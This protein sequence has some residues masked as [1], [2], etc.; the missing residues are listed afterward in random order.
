MRPLRDVPLL[1]L[2]A[3][4]QAQPFG[5]TPLD[6]ET[7]GRSAPPTESV[8]SPG[9]DIPGWED[10]DC[11]EPADGAG[12]VEM[13]MPDVA[14]TFMNR[15]GGLEADYA[16]LD[17]GVCDESPCSDAGEFVTSNQPFASAYLWS[18]L[19]HVDGRGQGIYGPSATYDG[20]NRFRLFG[21]TVIGEYYNDDDDYTDNVDATFCLSRVRPDMMEGTIRLAPRHGEV[22]SLW[23][24]SVILVIHVLI[25]FADHA[26]TAYN[27]PT[28]AAAQ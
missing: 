2:T 11:G 7:H 9:D 25:P 4:C 26:G 12:Y 14:R 5:Q 8:W 19:D 21:R 3:A 13:E 6:P 27:Y 17:V 15:Y 10:Y 23:Y 18:S 22:E 28:D 20:G 24:S 16:Y 1:L